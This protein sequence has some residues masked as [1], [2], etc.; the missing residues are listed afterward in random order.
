MEKKSLQELYNELFN[1][2]QSRVHMMG[3][4]EFLGHYVYHLQYLTGIA[5]LRDPVRSKV[6]GATLNRF[7]QHQHNGQN[8]G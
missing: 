7:I 1:R 4:W 5:A 8:S 3:W 6:Y 2:I